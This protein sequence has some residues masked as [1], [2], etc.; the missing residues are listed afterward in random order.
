MKNKFNNPIVIS[1]FIIL[2]F[3][4]IMTR[5]AVNS[6]NKNADQMI[7]IIEEGN[8]MTQTK[9]DGLASGQEVLNQNDKVI[10]DQIDSLTIKVDSLAEE[11]GLLKEEV[12]ALGDTSDQILV[13]LQ[14]IKSTVTKLR[15]A[16][17]TSVTASEI[18]EYNKCIAASGGT[19]SFCK[20]ILD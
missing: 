18:I 14:S 8:A 12:S 5:V 3:G 19:N 1:T 16:G 7:K 2:I 11:L 13:E 9:L 10:S 17:Y 20:S 15:S 6:I 4:L